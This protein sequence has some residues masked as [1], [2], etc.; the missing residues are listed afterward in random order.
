MFVWIK[1]SKKKNTEIN[2]NFILLYLILIKNFLKKNIYI[3]TF[4]FLMSLN[5]ILFINNFWLNSRFEFLN[6]IDNNLFRV[7]ILINIYVYIDEYLYIYKIISLS[8]IMFLL[9][10]LLRGSLPRY[11]ILDMQELYWKYL[12]ILSFIILVFFLF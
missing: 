8:L 7:D 2:I 10:L 4:T 6:K 11:K 9:L 1:I 5:F 12:L 3:I